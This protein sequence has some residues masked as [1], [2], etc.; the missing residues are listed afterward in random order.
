MTIEYEMRHLPHLKHVG[1]ALIDFDHSLQ[2]AVFTKKTEWIYS[3]NFVGFAIRYKRVEKIELLISTYPQEIEN[4][5]ILPLYTARW[6]GYMR[7]EITSPRQ[8][9][10][11]ARYIE[12]SYHVWHRWDFR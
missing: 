4:R 1:L 11:A 6:S 2:K 3:Q 10:C 7:A 12:A 9:A 5:E 8:L